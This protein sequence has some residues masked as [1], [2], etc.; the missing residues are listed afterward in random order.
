MNDE[1]VAS[2]VRLE[3]AMWQETTRFDPDFMARHL[4]AD[5]REFGRSGRCYTREQ[6][7]QAPHQAI[8]AVL[9]LPELR[10]DPLGA[11][12]VL[13]TYQSCT[14]DGERLLKAWRS[15]IWV[16]AGGEWKMRFHQGTPI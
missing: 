13:L 2:L 7:L 5:F 15:S 1:D 3:E 9:P 16:H 10:V 14:R 12:V 11:D 8:D 4:S 6:V